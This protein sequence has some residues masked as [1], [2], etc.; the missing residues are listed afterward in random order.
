MQVHISP[1][2]RSITISTTSNGLL[3]FMKIKVAARH[4]S[5]RTLFHTMLILAFLLPFIF[6]LTAVMTLEGVNKC[7]S[8]DCLGRRLGPRFLG[9]GDDSERLVRDLYKL[10]NQV[11]AE[12]VPDGLKVPASFGDFVAEMKA[13]QYDAKTFAVKLKAMVEHLEKETRAAK[14]QEF[15]YKHFAA[16][17]IPKGIY[18][19]SLRLT[20]EYSSNANARRQLPPPEMLPTLTDNSFHHF[21]LATDNILAASVVVSSTVM[22]ALEP[23]KI[24]FHLITDKKTYAGM[25]S[26]FALNPPNPAIVE[27]K[28]VHQFDW[29][30]RENVPV[31]EAVES[32]VNIRRYY[33]GDHIKGTDLNDAPR[34]VA[35]K[36]QARSPKYI[37]IL[38][39]LRIYLPEL[40]PKLDKVVFLDDD[41]VIQ[42][43]LSPL[44]DIDLNGKVNG[45]VETCRGDD[46]WV[47][48]KRFRNYF[49]FSHPLVAKHLDPEECAWAY[50]M[51][52]F[53]LNAWR[54]TNIRD[55][56]D[57][58]L[59]EN[60]SS[61]LTLWRLGTLPPALIAFSG[62]VHP[63]DSSWHMLGLGY[64]PETNLENIKRA[65]VIHYNGQGKPW[66]EIGFKE[67]RPF[68]TKHVNY[69]NDFIRNCHIMEP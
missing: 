18:C 43:D 24:V 66:L 4:I 46:Q 10:L 37:S 48:S 39:H 8:L 65:A 11:N 61:N 2:M 30:T 29:L 58:W 13:N 68:W 28:G 26:W 69:S 36:L 62:H 63:I 31:L 50:G 53:D 33:H 49:N 32:H 5:Y 64:Q 45:A 52:I 1:S 9:R 51:N 15:L 44:W 41:V 54:K 40:F 6:I 19:L 55:T 27:V 21:I 60:L 3:D 17:G 20:D 42:R 23:G 12:E 14:L 7:S 67:L 22:A 35:S 57:N 59:K 16:S 47:M 38:N 34:L 56:Y 25:H